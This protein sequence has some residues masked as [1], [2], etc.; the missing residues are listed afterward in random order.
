MFDNDYHLVG[1]HAKYVRFLNAYTSKL[2]KEAK[3]AGIFEYAVDVYIIA[4]LIGIAYNRR[5]P[6]DTESDDKGAPPL[7]I[8]ASQ[9]ISRQAKLDTVYRLAMLSEKSTA[10][11]PD[12]RMERAFK[13]DEL[14][15]KADA[16]MELFHQYMRGGVE[17]LYE[18]ITEKA[19]MQEDYLERIKEIVLLYADDF[20]LPLSKNMENVP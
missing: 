8:L 10:L 7:N 9:I 20:D 6:V 15:E 11:L 17:W 18:H 14:P 5:A 1:K 12:E 16:N 2:D 13:E 3:V 19:T 4:P